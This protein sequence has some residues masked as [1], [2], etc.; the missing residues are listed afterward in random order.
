MR[1][2]VL[3]KDTNETKVQVSIKATFLKPG[4]SES[5]RRSSAKHIQ[6]GQLSP[7]GANDSSHAT[8][9]TSSQTIDLNTGIEFLDHVPQVQPKNPQKKPYDKAQKNTTQRFNL[10]YMLLWLHS[11]RKQA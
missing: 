5:G 6:A 3:N 11:P 9:S 7:N 4:V 10:H 1:T 8:Q 2:A